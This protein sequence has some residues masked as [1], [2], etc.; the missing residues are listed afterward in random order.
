MKVYVIPCSGI[1]KAVA[2]V[3]RDATYL[4][5]EELR[6]GVA[7]TLCLSL[8]TKGD[9]VAREEVR[10]NKVICI[11]GCGKDCARKNVE[12]AG[13]PPEVAHRVNDWLKRHRD[14]QPESVLEIGEGGRK[15]ARIMAEDL[16]GEVD[17]LLGERDEGGAEGAL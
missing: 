9:E 6:P 17:D 8:L 3:G 16:A 5:V 7:D 15:L 14:L 2:S 1:G 13:K 11:D 10:K 4:V 12:A